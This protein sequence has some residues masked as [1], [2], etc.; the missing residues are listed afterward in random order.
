[1]NVYVHDIISIIHMRLISFI[2]ITSSVLMY[3]RHLLAYTIKVS[4]D[5]AIMWLSQGLLNIRK[6][7]G[8]NWMH[9][10]TPNNA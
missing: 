10:T 7:H 4:N 6:E 5:G 8:Q 9:L 3:S 2:L 1:M